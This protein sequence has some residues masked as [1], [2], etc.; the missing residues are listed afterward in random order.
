MIGA[1]ICLA[2][3]FTL[4]AGVLSKRN[5]IVVIGAILLVVGIVIP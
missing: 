4:F 3:G 5:G 1:L 2:A